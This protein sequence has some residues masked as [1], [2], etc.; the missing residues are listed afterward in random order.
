MAD[1]RLRRLETGRTA[2]PKPQEARTREIRKIFA[3]WLWSAK[4]EEREPMEALDMAAQ[5]NEGPDWI[6]RM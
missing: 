4:L 6:E 5:R 3:Q 2:P 1:E